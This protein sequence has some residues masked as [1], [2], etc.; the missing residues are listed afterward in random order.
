MCRSHF[1]LQSPVTTNHLHS[2][3]CVKALLPHSNPSRMHDVCYLRGCLPKI[4]IP[5]LDHI[6]DFLEI[7]HVI[8]LHFVS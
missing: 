8:E 5:I 6:A 7:L 3:P 1:A 4:L 2:Y